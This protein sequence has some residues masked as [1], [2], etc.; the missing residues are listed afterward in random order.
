MP[1]PF[2]SSRRPGVIISRLS[3]VPRGTVPLGA[4]DYVT[5]FIDVQQDILFY[6]VAAWSSDFTGTIIDYGTEP[7]QRRHYFG[8][9]DLTKRLRD[10][11]DSPNVDGAILSGL[12]ELTGRLLSTPY[13][14]E[15]GIALRISRLLID[16]GYKNYLGYQV[17]R[18]AEN[19]QAAILSYGRTFR[20]QN[21]PLSEYEKRPGDQVGLNWMITRAVKRASRHVL[22]D[23]NFW[24]SFIF[25][26]LAVTPG[27]AGSL[28]LYGSDPDVHRLIGEHLTAEYATEI[29]SKTHGRT[30]T[31]FEPYPGR[32]NHWLD[33]LV[34]A[35][36]AASVAG[37]RL[38]AIEPIQKPV[39]QRMSLSEMASKAK[40]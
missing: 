13:F 3:R 38:P 5:A 1:T 12:Q 27:T 7:D 11:H 14:R 34:G 15:D 2:R 26:R 18:Q 8:L 30:V 39:R 23:A 37:A 40:R 33:C 17:C 24:K 6:L 36:V 29:E 28:T 32:D 10:K 4:G 20:P 19:L 16:G 22:F 35:A 31:V 25:N 21:K 9:Q